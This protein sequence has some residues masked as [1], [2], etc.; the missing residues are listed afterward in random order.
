MLATW[1]WIL[2]SCLAA[3]VATYVLFVEPPPPR[4]I[5]IACGNAAPGVE[6]DARL[7][8]ADPEGLAAAI[9]EQVAVLHA[10]RMRGPRDTPLVPRPPFA[11]GAVA[12]WV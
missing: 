4:K 3:L 12:G 5:I 11:G 9:L 8:T 6:V 1:L 10:E 7:P 2:G